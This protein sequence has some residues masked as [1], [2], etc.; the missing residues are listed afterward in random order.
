MPIADHNLYKEYPVNY[1]VVPVAGYRS[2][3]KEVFKCISKEIL[4]QEQHIRIV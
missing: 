4:K 3:P 1:T 2:V